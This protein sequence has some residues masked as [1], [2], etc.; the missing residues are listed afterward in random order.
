MSNQHEIFGQRDSNPR[1]LEDK[2]SAEVL[3]K[4]VSGILGVQI[5]TIEKAFRETDGPKEREEEEIRDRM[6]PGDISFDELAWLAQGLNSD[7]LQ[8]RAVIRRVRDIL[9]APAPSDK[10]GV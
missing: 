9:T 2:N 3:M 7:S 8:M 5:G 4:R 1:S 10:P 6:L